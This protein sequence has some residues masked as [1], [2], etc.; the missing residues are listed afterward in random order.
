M[1][2]TQFS[3]KNVIE[4]NDGLSRLREYYDTHSC[5]GMLIHIYTEILD[6]KSIKSAIDRIEDVLPEAV[7]VYF[8]VSFLPLGQEF[9]YQYCNQL[10]GQYST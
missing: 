8:Q 4:L 7:Q 1:Q 2:Q 3:F 10:M 6:S 5:Y 9:Q